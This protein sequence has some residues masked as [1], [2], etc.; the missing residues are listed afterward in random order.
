MTKSSMKTSHQNF[1]LRE[2]EGVEII[3]LTNDHADYLSII[4]KEVPKI[5]VKSANSYLGYF[6]YFLFALPKK[7]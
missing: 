7:H 6:L 4:Q 2:D 1:K 3:S 5:S